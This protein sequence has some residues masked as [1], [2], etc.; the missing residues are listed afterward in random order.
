MKSQRQAVRLALCCHSNAKA[1]DELAA[2]STRGQVLSVVLTRIA[3]VLIRDKFE[4]LP[5]SLKAVVDQLA[6]E[7]GVDDS[8]L[9]ISAKQERGP[10]AVRIEVSAL[11]LAATEVA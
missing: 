2:A 4:N 11:P 6:E 9:E 8:E 3:P 10:Y 5:M 1:F 7:L